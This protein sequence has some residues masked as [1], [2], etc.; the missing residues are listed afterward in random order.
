VHRSEVISV[1]VAGDAI[2]LFSAVALAPGLLFG[3][4]LVD[5]LLRKPALEIWSGPDEA[6]FYR[7]DVR[8][9]YLSAF[10]R[11]TTART[12]GA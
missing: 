5:G 8:W 7:L 6:Q 1:E 9:R 11:K 10:C 4:D 2:R 12:Q 3:A